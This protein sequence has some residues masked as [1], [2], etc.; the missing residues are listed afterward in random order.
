[1][2]ATHNE[3][4][5]EGNKIDDALT[6]M[7]KIVMDKSTIPEQLH[8]VKAHGD[9]KVARLKVIT[10]AMDLDCSGCLHPK[11]HHVSQ[12]GQCL[13]FEDAGRCPCK[14]WNIDV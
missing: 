6:L 3:L 14:Q 10:K 13:D 11:D 9:A 5:A 12:K 8:Q 7:Q 4:V 1:M 2:M